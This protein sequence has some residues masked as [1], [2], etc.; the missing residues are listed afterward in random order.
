M[1][2]RLAS[3]LTKVCSSVQDTKGYIKLTCAK[4]ILAVKGAF[5]ALPEIHQILV[6]ETPIEF[7]SLLLKKGF[8]NESLDVVHSALKLNEQKIK[9]RAA[10]SLG[11]F[12][13]HPNFIGSEQ[14]KQV[15]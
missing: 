11:E 9:N 13:K 12:E 8:A 15:V 10:S 3:L 5:E 2:D 4:A 6:E 7:A 14:F 1:K